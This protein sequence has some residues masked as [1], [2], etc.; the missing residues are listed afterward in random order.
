MSQKYKGGRCF[1]VQT[2]IR[3]PRPQTENMY[4]VNSTWYASVLCTVEAAIIGLVPKR[5][6]TV[7]GGLRSSDS[8]MRWIQTLDARGSS[9]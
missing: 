4:T 3:E 9:L 7:T 1:Y 6:G 8:T 2:D 5:T